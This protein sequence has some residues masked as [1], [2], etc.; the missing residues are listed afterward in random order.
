[1]DCLEPRSAWTFGKGLVPLLIILKRSNYLHFNFDLASL[2]IYNKMS[3]TSRLPVID[4][5]L[6]EECSKFNDKR[7]ARKRMDNVTQ[8]LANRVALLKSTEIK[9]V[10]KL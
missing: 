9:A 6:K 7:K 3:Y 8:A 2:I 10:E 5:S 4:E 1:M